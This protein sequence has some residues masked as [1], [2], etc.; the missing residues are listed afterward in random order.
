ME[1]LEKQTKCDTM[2]RWGIFQVEYK[3]S[4][5]MLAGSWRQLSL[6]RLVQFPIQVSIS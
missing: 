2:Q 6:V 5:L 3:R 1:W 4:A